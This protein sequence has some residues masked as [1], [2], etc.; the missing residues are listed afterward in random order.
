MGVHNI[1][2][3]MISVGNKSDVHLENN[4]CSLKI[5]AKTKKGNI[6]LLLYKNYLCMQIEADLSKL[7]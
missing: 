5:S 7:K 6:N 2:K 3:K 1:Q 4:E